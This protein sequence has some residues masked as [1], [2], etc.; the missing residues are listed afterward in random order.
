M[1]ASPIPVLLIIVGTLVFQGMLFGSELAEKSFP[2]LEKPEAGDCEG[3]IDGFVC[4]V[5]Y[6]VDFFRVLFGVIAFFFN[7]I[8]FNVPGA[9]WFVRAF[10]GAAM[11]CA[12]LWSVVTL[13]RGN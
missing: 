2:T 13:F 11:G 8:T 4:G 6:V 3:L 10:L 7:L 12:I 9:P 5:N 1:A